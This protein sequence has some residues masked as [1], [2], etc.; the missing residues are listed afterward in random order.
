MKKLINHQWLDYVSCGVELPDDAG[1]YQ[2]VNGFIKNVDCI[3][4][5]DSKRFFTIDQIK[6][7]FGGLRIY[8]SLGE[9]MPDWMFRTI[10]AYTAV[11]ELQVS[12]YELWKKYL[13]LEVLREA[14]AERYGTESE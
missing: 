9:G 14:E 1:W 2:A 6:E 13:H 7:K 4:P 3:M 12:N 11:A 5:E 10:D 8:W